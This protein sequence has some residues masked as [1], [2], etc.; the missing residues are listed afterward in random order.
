MFGV[1]YMKLTQ[2]VARQLVGAFG[3]SLRKSE[4]GE[5]VIRLKST[6][7]TYETNDLSDAIYTALAMYRWSRSQVVN[8]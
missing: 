7:Q 2:S 8:Q 4:Y 3:V 6:G 5:Y 1:S